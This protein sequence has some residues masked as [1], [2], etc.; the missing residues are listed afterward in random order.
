MVCKMD[1]EEQINI[2]MKKVVIIIVLIIG[3]VLT[4]QE[5]NEDIRKVFDGLTTAWQE[6][7]GNAWGDFF[8]EDA[9][10][11]VWFG[12]HLKGRKEISDGHQWVFDTVYP[13]TRYEFTITQLRYLGPD[14]AVVHLNASILGP[15]EDLPTD[16]H[17]LPVAVLQK[18]KGQW[19]IAMFH[20]MD[21]R[22][23]EIEEGR[24]KGIL[25]D[26]RQ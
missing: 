6:A 9:D 10:F 7:N 5:S 18:L 4:A 8:L 19:K 26:V 20:N 17:T 24:K 11:T 14:I 3:Q 15:G 2:M 22:L 16:P 12:L 25:G 1:Y 21:N 23:K 13:N